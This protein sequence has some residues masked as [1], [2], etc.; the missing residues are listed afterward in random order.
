MPKGKNP[1]KKMQQKASSP[2]KPSHAPKRR[3]DYNRMA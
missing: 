2:R 1:M 3:K